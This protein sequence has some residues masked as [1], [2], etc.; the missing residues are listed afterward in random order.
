MKTIV[1]SAPHALGH[2]R[3][4]MGASRCPGTRSHEGRRVLNFAADGG[5]ADFL[6]RTGARIFSRTRAR[7]GDRNRPG[8]WPMRDHADRQPG[9]RHRLATFSTLVRIRLASPPEISPRAVFI[10]HNRSPQAVISPRAAGYQSRPICTAASW[11]RS[12]GCPSRMFPRSRTSPGIDTA[13]PDRDPPVQPAAA[14]HH[15]KADRCVDAVT[16]SR[17]GP[18]CSTS[19]LTASASMMPRSSRCDR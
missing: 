11:A 1:G 12:G 6:P 18:S 3:C 17:S 8:V 9:V 19:K 7:R 2:F 4:S 14:R 5:A 16:G 15:V 13:Q 10:L